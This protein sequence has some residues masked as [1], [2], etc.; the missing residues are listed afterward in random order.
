MYSWSAPE[1]ESESFD[2]FRG[3]SDQVETNV[4][5]LPAEHRLS[6]RETSEIAFSIS[7]RSSRC[8]RSSD[9]LS[10]FLAR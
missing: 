2:S 4:W 9:S 10:W 6:S 3:Y 5:A 1:N 7:A 8:F